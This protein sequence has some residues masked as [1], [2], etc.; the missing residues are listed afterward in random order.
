MQPKLLFWIY[1]WFGPLPLCVSYFVFMLQCL[2]IHNILKWAQL[3][4]CFWADT[5]VLIFSLLITDTN[6]FALLKQ[7][8]WCLMR[9]NKHTWTL[10]LFCLQPNMIGW[11]GHMTRLEHITCLIDYDVCNSLFWWTSIAM[12]SVLTNCWQLRVC[13]VWTVH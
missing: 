13:I 2:Q 10:E 5:D 11:V 7:W 8:I 9:P 4:R 6:I 3:I 12:V 1:I